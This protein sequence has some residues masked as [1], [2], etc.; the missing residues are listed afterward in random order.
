MS[1][2]HPTGVEII[3]FVLGGIAPGLPCVMAGPSGSGRTVLCVQLALAALASGR[4]VI[5]LCNEPVP[6][7]LQQTATLGFDLESPLRSGQ[8][9]LLELDIANDGLRYEDAIFVVSKR[10]AVLLLVATE[11]ADAPT[12]VKNP[13]AGRR[14][15]G[16]AVR[17]SS[18]V[19]TAAPV[20]DDHDWRTLFREDSDGAEDSPE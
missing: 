2:L 8:L 9:V 6:F 19:R 13:R 15:R 4:V 5:Y 17:L 7:L 20:D 18:S 11:A 16:R 3:D 12:I 10:R 14:A 1:S